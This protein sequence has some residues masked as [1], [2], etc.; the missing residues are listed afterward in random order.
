MQAGALGS[1]RPLR[2][3]ALHLQH[4]GPSIKFVGFRAVLY[5]LEEQ[6]AVGLMLNQTRLAKLKVRLF[7]TGTEPHF[8]NQAINKKD[9]NMIL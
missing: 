7:Q 4:F 8:L 6:D 2:D 3:A 1:V 9:W 5:V